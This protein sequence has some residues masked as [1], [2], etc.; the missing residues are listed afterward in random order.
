MEGALLQSV[1]QNSLQTIWSTLNTLACQQQA[2]ATTGLKFFKKPP[3]I[4]GEM[5]KERFWSMTKE[6]RLLWQ[7]SKEEER[8]AL[9]AA[10]GID[11]AALLTK[12]NV[13]R[14]RADGMTFAA[15]ARDIIGT[16]QEAVAATLKGP[17]RQH[18][19]QKNINKH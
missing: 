17:T 18:P 15:I 2:S 14:W 4:D 19:I 5:T 6:E 11:G 8:R 9:N 7:R 13:E 1:R 10:A 12:E 3:Q 16:S